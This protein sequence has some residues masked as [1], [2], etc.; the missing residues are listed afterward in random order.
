M[1]VFLAA[2]SGGGEKAST[3]KE[4]KDDGKASGE[5]QEGGTVTF[6]YTQPFKG[7]LSYAYYEG[8]DDVNALKFMHEGIFNTSEE[9]T[10]VPGL[11]DWEMS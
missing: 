11:A 3:D 2:C 4:P 8:E 9:L 5:A 1:S 10:T 6:G 7:V